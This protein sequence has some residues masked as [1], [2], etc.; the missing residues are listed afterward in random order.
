MYTKLDILNYALTALGHTPVAHLDVEVPIAEGFHRVYD[1]EL[2]A[3]LSR[4]N[5][6]F[7]NK[8]VQVVGEI[9]SSDKEYKYHYN[10]PSDLV[11][12]RGVYALSKN[13][14]PVVADDRDPIKGALLPSGPLNFDS[15]PRFLSS[16]QDPSPVVLQSDYKI[17][18]GVL[19]T[20][21]KEPLVSYT[22][23]NDSEI[24]ASAL[25][26]QAL[27]Y[28]VASLLAP[29]A[30]NNENDVQRLRMK[31]EQAIQL[32]MTEDS[33]Q[34]DNQSRLNQLNPIN[35]YVRGDR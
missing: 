23:W 9:D 3:L 21:I 34:G 5:W 29:F 7:V 24:T 33:R 2:R 28:S 19:Y 18:Q 27:A 35:R 17:S 31:A 10:L 8:T 25:F 32:A 30:N 1:V 20:H 12:I 6:T 22:Y 14:N 15:S 4:R 11:S 13:A 26:V 16:A